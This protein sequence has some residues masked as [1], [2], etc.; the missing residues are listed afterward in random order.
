MMATG[1]RRKPEESDLLT[2]RWEKKKVGGGKQIEGSQ[3][4]VSVLLVA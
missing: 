2:E 1:L 4:D 3:H